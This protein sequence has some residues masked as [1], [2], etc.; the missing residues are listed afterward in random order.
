MQH[1][2]THSPGSGPGA[3]LGAVAFIHRFGSTLNAHLHFHCV[4][5]DGVFDATATGGIDF[6]AAAGLGAPAVAA[7]QSCVRRRLLRIFVRRDLLPGADARATAQWEHGGGFSMRRRASRP[8]TVPDVSGCC[9]TTEGSP[10]WDCARPP[11]ALERL[12]QLDPERLLYASN[13]PQTIMHLAQLSLGFCL[14][15]DSASNS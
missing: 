8:L 1:L 6:R 15:I 9:A 10:F 11:L 2:R 3:R 14:C 12:R 13:Q 4:V 7:V 5:I